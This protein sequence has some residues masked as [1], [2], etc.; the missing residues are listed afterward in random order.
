[1]NWF[2]RTLHKPFF[3]RLFNWEY[4]SFNAVYGC[5]MPV[6]LLLSVRARSFFFFSASNPSIEYGGFLM[7]SKKK[8]YDIIP[9][10]Y[11][12]RTIYILYGTNPQQVIVQLQSL[13]F[14]YPLIGK[15]DIGGQGRGVKKLHNEAELICYANISPV[16]YLIQEFVSQPNEVGVFYYR[17]PGDAVGHVSGIVR[18][19]LL[20]VAGDGVSTMNELLLKDKRFI[21]QMPVLT[22]LYS[23]TLN[24]VL[25]EGEIKELVPYGNHA[26]GAKFLDDSHL[27]DE[28]FTKTI[29]D[30]CRQVE[31]F[32][33]GRLDIR[34]NTWEELRQG[35]NIS[36]IELNGAGSE[37][38]H[39]Y[40]P[41][42]SLFFAWKEI[43]RHWIILWRISRINHKKGIPYLSQKQGMQM[44]KDNKLFEQKLQ[45]F[46]V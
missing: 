38:T 31:G 1:M 11:Y 4:W 21:L 36:I 37:P 32:Y 24:E 45:Q 35:E 33:Y 26:R 46:Y 5:I 29:D 18:K 8:I 10:H 28:V 42:H 9:Q 34:Y 22:K 23:D 2:Q 43:I 44:M 20:A 15:P 3:I 14:R 25:P 39:M 41:T 12:P 6:W 7:E 27:A 40:D 19:E 13:D 17:Y 16:D 30:I